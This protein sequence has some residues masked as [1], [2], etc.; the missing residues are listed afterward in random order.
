MI[1]TLR[2][3]LPFPVLTGLPFGHVARKV[4]LP[5]GAPGTLILRDG[6]FSLRFSGH[7]AK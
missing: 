4:T 2:T 7:N 5:F 3:F 6:G 1:E